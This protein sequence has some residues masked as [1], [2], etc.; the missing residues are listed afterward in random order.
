M[1]N[2]LRIDLTDPAMQEAFADCQP[3]ETHT[4][5]FDITVSENA[6]ELVADVDPDSVEKY[7]DDYEEGYEEGESPNAVALII[8]GDAEKS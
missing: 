5:T 1:A 4:V 2:E 8:K 7:G 6:E 3:G